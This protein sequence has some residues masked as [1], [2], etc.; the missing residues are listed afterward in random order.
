MCEGGAG[1]Q[2]SAGV[3]EDVSVKLLRV[4]GEESLTEVPQ[5]I[6]P[7][8][9]REGTARGNAPRKASAKRG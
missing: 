7:A 6:Q 2:T 9:A 1:G 3:V 8:A 4:A 5:P